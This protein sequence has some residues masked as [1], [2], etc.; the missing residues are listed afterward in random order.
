MKGLDR[1]TKILNEYC[2]QFDCVCEPSDD[3]YYFYDSS[4]VT[5]AFVTTE[6]IDKQFVKF[7]ETLGLNVKCDTFLLSL[8]HEIGH[9]H[10]IEEVEE[11]DYIY[12]QDVKDWIDEQ[13]ASE[14]LLDMYF[15]LPDEKIAT[16]WAVDYINT[17]ID[18]VYN[19]WLRL[20]PAILDFYK[21]NKIE[22]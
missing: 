14:E 9:H 21:K 1:I 16:Q 3:F 20:Q 18:E 15:N 22:G 12:S 4:T 17:H 7:Y 5:F 19:L 10:T 13:E 8:F 2:K 11:E 6:W